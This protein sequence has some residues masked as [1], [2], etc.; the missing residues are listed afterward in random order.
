MESSFP[1]PVST[2]YY[3]NPPSAQSKDPL[4]LPNI[5]DMTRFIPDEPRQMAIPIQPLTVVPTSQPQSLSSQPQSLST[6]QPQ[7]LSTSQPQSLSSQPQSL[8]SQPQSMTGLKAMPSIS[9]PMA[10]IALPAPFIASSP[11]PF[12]SSTGYYPSSPGSG[13]GSVVCE[14]QTGLSSESVSS[15]DMLSDSQVVA[16]DEVCECSSGAATPNT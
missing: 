9:F 11:P 3:S 7:S 16:A 13:V 10:P 12:F 8:S 2:P 4:S 15:V 1:F 14:P 6:S 5:P